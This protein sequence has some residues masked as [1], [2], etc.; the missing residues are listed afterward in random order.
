MSRPANAHNFWES[1]KILVNDLTSLPWITRLSLASEPPIAYITFEWTLGLRAQLSFWV[2]HNS[3]SWESHDPCRIVRER[4]APLLWWLIHKENQINPGLI[5]AWSFLLP[6]NPALKKGCVFRHLLLWPYEVCC[7]FGI[8][9]TLHFT[10]QLLLIRH[11]HTNCRDVQACVLPGFG[12]ARSCWLKDRDGEC[13]N[14]VP[15]NINPTECYKI[16]KA[17]DRYF[18]THQVGSSLPL[19]QAQARNSA[20]KDKGAVI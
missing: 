8:P 12:W 16:N 18:H 9:V 13:N 11:T 15:R 2:S 3:N 14:T 19:D 1:L 4:S 6:L 17:H 10:L 20:H 5:S 7:G